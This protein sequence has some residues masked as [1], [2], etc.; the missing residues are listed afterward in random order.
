MIIYTY[1]I[2]TAFT[3]RDIEMIRPHQPIK[4]LPFTNDPVKL[5]F[6]FIL[7]FFQLLFLLPMTSKYL[8]FFAGYHSVLPVLL[9]KL[10]GIKVFIQSGGTDAMNMPE[11]NYGNF[12]KKWLRK[13]TVYSFKNCNMILPVAESLVQCDYTY[14]PQIDRRQG[15]KNLIPDLQT[16][17]HVIHNGFDADFWVDSNKP[18]PPFSFITVAVGITQANRAAVKG[19]DLI[20]EMAKCFP[21]YSFSLVGDPDFRS[22]L[23]NVKVIGKLTPDQLKEAFNQ[24][25]F[26]LQLS[27]SEGFPNALAEAM[28]CGCI[29]IGSAVGA[30]PEII[31]DTGFVLQQKNTDQLQQLLLQ[32]SKEDLNQLRTVARERVKSHFSYE[33]RQ[34]ALLALLSDEKQP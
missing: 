18:K 28:L 6:Y 29:P 10:F 1:P 4:A 23:P 9:G 31:G 15:I 20:L 30:I 2:A 34:K 26:Y 3:D 13:A 32:L 7:Q 17:I 33:K 27:T 12:R 8:C 11:I 16:P 5:P 22:E 24:H 14:D 25:Q 19:I 21:H